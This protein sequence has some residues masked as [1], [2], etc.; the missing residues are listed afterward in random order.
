[1]QKTV[2]R[3]VELSVYTPVKRV[4]RIL[5][6]IVLCLIVAGILSSTFRILQYPFP[7]S[8]WFHKM[9]DLDSEYNI[10]AWYASFS[11][12][13]CAGLL[14]VV[15]AIKK[16]DRYHSYWKV[17]AFIFLFLGLD[18]VFSFHEALIIP[19][20]RKSLQLNSFFYHTWVIPAI[21]LV[22]FFLFKYWKFVLHLP[23]RTRN[24]MIFAGGIYITGALG[25]EMVSGAVREAYGR[26][27]VLTQAVIISE[28]TLEKVGILIFIYALLTYLVKLTD[29]LT[30][31]FQLV[32]EMAKPREPVL[33]DENAPDWPQ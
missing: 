9:F 29:R 18:E 33:L 10:P 13:F 21:V 23:Q 15:T 6:T 30:I 1:M 8:K 20:L 12:L 7:A 24:L 2:V 11:L 14:A 28:E 22:G 26:W 32:P 25:I 17:L 4:M 27:N 16:G 3:Q 19:S 5:I 31:N